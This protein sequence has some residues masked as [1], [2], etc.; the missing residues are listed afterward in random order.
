[1]ADELVILQGA[2][3]PADGES[4]LPIYALIHLGEGGA[5]GMRDPAGALRTIS[6]YDALHLIAGRLC[7]P[8]HG[9]IARLARAIGASDRGMRYWLTGNRPVPSPAAH[10]MAYAIRVKE[11]EK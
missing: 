4:A 1:M 9:K 11:L 6:A 8:E 10:A 2:R 7:G 5:F 3:H